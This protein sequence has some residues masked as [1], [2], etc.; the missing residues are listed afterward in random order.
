MS[1]STQINRIRKNVTDT[2]QIIE[3]A[4]VTV[5]QGSDA[6]PAAASALVGRMSKTATIRSGTDV[7]DNSLGVDGDVYLM[8]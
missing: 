2:L 3:N 5:G 1:V 7:P 8:L 6:L 4:G